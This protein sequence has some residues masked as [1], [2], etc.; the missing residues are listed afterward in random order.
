METDVT[1]PSIITE[2]N[3]F[4]KHQSASEDVSLRDAGADEHEERSA[5]WASDHGVQHVDRD[6]GRHVLTATSHRAQ[7]RERRRQIHALQQPCN[8]SINQQSF[9]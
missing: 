1:L 8:R 2:K 9:P 6:T 7:V 3:W 4:R 5:M